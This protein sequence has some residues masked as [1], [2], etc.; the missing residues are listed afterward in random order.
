MSECVS[1]CPGLS[2][3]AEGGPRK[4]FFKTPGWNLDR[5]GRMPAAVPQTPC[6]AR[7]GVLRGKRRASSKI[8]MMA[9]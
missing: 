2:R 9:R 7:A 5:Q 8:R 3:S 6:R 4:R 1:I